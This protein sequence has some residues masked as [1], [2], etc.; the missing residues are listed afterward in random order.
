MALKELSAKQVGLPNHLGSIDL[1]DLG[2]EANLFDLSSHGKLRS[3]LSF[4]LKLRR[5]GFHIFVMGDERTSRMPATMSCLRELTG[6]T[7]PA[8]DWVYLNNFRAVQRPFAFALGAGFGQSL[9]GHMGAMLL[10]I[11]ASL[12]RTLEAEG[13]N[14]LFRK[15]NAS[16]EDDFSQQI[17]AL[18]EKAKQQGFSISKTG[19]GNFLVTPLDPHPQEAGSEPKVDQLTSAQMHQARALLDQ[20]AVLGQ[21]AHAAEELLFKKRKEDRLAAAKKVITPYVEDLYQKF[22]E[23]VG[24]YDWV[25]LLKKD[26]ISQFELFLETD[27]E[28]RHGLTEELKLRYAVNVL[29]DHSGQSRMPIVTVSH[30]SYENLFG[31]IKY[32]GIDGGGVDTDFTLIRPGALHK[33]NGGILVIQAETLA[34]QPEI[35]AFLKRA[36][37]NHE[38][39]I[40][41]FHRHNGMPMMQA[42]DPQPIPLDVQVVLVGAPWWFDDFFIADPE[43]RSLFKV[44][45]EIDLCMPASPENVTTY[46]RLISQWSANHL[47]MT[48]DL[49]AIREIL[50]HSSRWTG[51]RG[52]LS[53]RFELVGD[54]LRE[55]RIFAQE[56][57]AAELTGADIESVFTYRQQRKAAGFLKHLDEIMNHRLH[58]ETEGHII[59]QINALTVLTSVESAFGTASRLTA[60]TFAA[61][62]GVVSIERSIEMSG[63]I[64]DKGIMILTG[65]LNAVFGQHFPLSF[66][67]SLTFEQLYVP[68]DGDSASLA[69]LIVMLSSLAD[70]PVAQHI[71]LTG[72][73]DQLGNVQA[74]GGVH[75]KIEGFYAL[76]KLRGF[77]GDQG[78][79]LPASNE[80]DLTLPRE[81]EES[82]AK[83]EF[84][85]WTADRVEDAVPL[86]L[87]LPLGLPMTKRIKTQEETV[88]TRVHKKLTGY[89]KIMKED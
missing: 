9:K 20:M 55:A 68:I 36:L 18:Y 11:Q 23:V 13:V 6:D 25:Q 78:V 49:S 59:G 19:E 48:C 71:A 51:H 8:K 21:K 52:H 67:A 75:E 40:E 27:E 77:T 34:S 63:A 5:E 3:A 39:V 74:V 22:K 30:A 33:A 61:K 29:V 17:N 12:L 42:P 65:Y 16:L 28:G 57:G 4:S 54:M 69:E 79:L 43:F 81:I 46:A 58:I 15:E 26:M 76:C 73:V 70:L 56:R 37:Q 38:I 35:W 82:V 32:R 31:S 44:R 45:A 66:G 80:V 88:L 41:E 60:R 47:N 84:H 89:V 87:G 7:E 86:M 1:Q 72:S 24:F 10:S 53:G 62:E 50:G 64:Q 14:E 2:C 83:G 85:L